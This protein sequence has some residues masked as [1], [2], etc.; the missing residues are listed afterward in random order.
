MVFLPACNQGTRH[1]L[2]VFPRGRKYKTDIGLPRAEFYICTGVIGLRQKN[3]S[4]VN[5]RICHANQEEK[6]TLKLHEQKIFGQ[7][8]P[9]NLTHSPLV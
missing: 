7:N 5:M 6:F 2:P 4:N 1:T 8:L 3:I 9:R